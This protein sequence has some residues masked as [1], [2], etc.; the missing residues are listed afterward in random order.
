[1]C[2]AHLILIVFD[3]RP[4]GVRPLEVAG[5]LLNAFVGMATEYDRHL[6]AAGAA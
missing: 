6:A 3:A 5:P 4:P 1:L 2:L